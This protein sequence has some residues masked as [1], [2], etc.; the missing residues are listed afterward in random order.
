MEPS[1]STIKKQT[2]RTV[3]LKAQTLEFL[4]KKE[5]EETI[6][7]AAEP[8]A[9]GKFSQGLTLIEELPTCAEIL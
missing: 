4:E 9:M 5:I 1:V 3:P 2:E 8:G 6:N 7:I